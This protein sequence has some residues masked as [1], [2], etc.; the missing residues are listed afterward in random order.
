M[1]SHKLGAYYAAE[2]NPVVLS[3]AIYV[4]VLCLVPIFTSKSAK[5]VVVILDSSLGRL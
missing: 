2:S 5:A 4:Y 3:H 1:I